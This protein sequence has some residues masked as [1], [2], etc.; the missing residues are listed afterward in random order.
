MTACQICNN[1]QDNKIHRVKEMMLGTGHS[2]EY[3]ECAE[4]HCL[5]LLNTPESPEESYPEAYYSFAI[6][7]ESTTRGFNRLLSDMKTRASVSNVNTL[8]NRLSRFWL[9][10]QDDYALLRRLSMHK[11]TRFIDVGTGSGKFLIPLYLA[12]YTNC[13][14][15]DRFIEGDIEYPFGL[16]IKK[17]TVFDL[18]GEYDL[19]F[20]NHSFEHIPEQRAELLRVGDILARS[21]ICVI[22]V[23]VFPSLA[24]D[25]YGVNWYQIDAPRHFFLHSTQSMAFLA[26]SAGFKV[27]SVYYNSTYAQF[28]ISKIY[29]KGIALKDRGKH[30]ESFLLRKVNKLKYSRW[31]R[32]Q[33]DKG[34]G[35][36][37]VFFLVRND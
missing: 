22:S 32:E 2:Y 12:G 26:E 16:K 30:K 23:P 17:A 27:S 31:A 21:G 36:Q 28:A 33:N 25:I 13:L 35:D 37:A 34:Y 18:Q 14:G 10:E 15:I 20:Y 1:A 7:N 9:G 11:N 19:V 4:C 5:Q 8:S 6:R 24:W 29:K 3:L